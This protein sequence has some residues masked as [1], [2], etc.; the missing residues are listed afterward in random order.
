MWLLMF[1]TMTL[2]TGLGSWTAK[3]RNTAIFKLPTQSWLYPWSCGGSPQSRDHFPFCAFELSDGFVVFG[4]EPRVAYA[5]SRIV[6]SASDWDGSQPNIPKDLQAAPH[7]FRK[8][9]HIKELTW[10]HSSS[11]ARKVTRVRVP[12]QVLSGPQVSQNSGRVEEVRD[13]FSNLFLQ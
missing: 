9:S 2:P 3:R 6:R 7:I 12:V 5:R 1:M 10:V 13:K 8:T 11:F 4:L